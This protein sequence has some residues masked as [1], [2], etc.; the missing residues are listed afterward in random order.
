MSTCNGCK[1]LF[2]PFLRVIFFDI[3]QQD[4]AAYLIQFQF[5]AISNSH[6]PIITQSCWWVSGWVGGNCRRVWERERWEE[7]CTLYLT[8][9]ITFEMNSQSLDD[10][11]AGG[12]FGPNWLALSSANPSPVTNLLPQIFGCQSNPGRL[13]TGQLAQFRSGPHNY[14][15][16]DQILI[17]N[18]ARLHRMR[19]GRFLWI[20][21]WLKSH[22][23]VGELIK[24]FRTLLGIFEEEKLH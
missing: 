24:V 3:L 21:D 4:G 19:V 18:F 2:H 5:Y 15:F 8:T 7:D 10:A 6:K 23:D 20:W 1:S 16:C 9:N 11:W 17:Q 22:L 14:T 12:K 13:K